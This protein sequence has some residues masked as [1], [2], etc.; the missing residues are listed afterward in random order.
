MTHCGNYSNPRNTVYPNQAQICAVFE[1]LTGVNANASA[2]F[3]NVLEN[4]DWTIEG[5]HT[6]WPANI[7]TGRSWKP[8]LL[9]STLPAPRAAHW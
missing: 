1:S 3:A 9:G 4:V 6:P 8:R 7:A 2:F 5:T